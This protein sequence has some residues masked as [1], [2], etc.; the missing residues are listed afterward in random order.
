MKKEVDLES[1]VQNFLSKRYIREEVELDEYIIKALELLES[2]D[3]F[4]RNRENEYEEKIND[5]IQWQ[6]THDMYERSYEYV[7]G[8]LSLF[9]LGQLQSCEASC[10]TAI[11]GAVNL[12]FVSIGDTTDKIVSYFKNHFEV[13]KKQNSS[14]EKA[15]DSSDVEDELK[16][17]HRSLIDKKYEALSSYEAVLKKVMAEHNVDISLSET[18]WPSA[19]DRFRLID[20]E[21][22][23]RTIYTALCSQSH[24]DPEDL[25]NHLICR[26]FGHDGFTAAKKAEQ[27]F[28]SLY[29]VLQAV[30]YH[31]M[32]SVMYLGKFDIPM[33]E[34]TDKY[35][36]TLN[37]LMQSQ[38]HKDILLVELSK[39]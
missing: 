1:Y 30:K 34:L 37:L 6:I 3:S 14:W 15:V 26:A 22:G 27:Y 39:Q 36:E 24:N 11:E 33:I 18:R 2:T 12:H 21:I 9:I 28:F 20:D 4:V 13:E 17:Y 23:Y 5:K 16:E 38:K 31:I 7:C 35:K 19:Y 32:A 29:M 10:R 8:S 25:L